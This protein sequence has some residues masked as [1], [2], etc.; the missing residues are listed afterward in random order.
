[1]AQL[2][3]TNRGAMGEPN[4]SP[5]TSPALEWITTKG[6]I[7]EREIRLFFSLYHIDT[8][9]SYLFLETGNGFPYSPIGSSSHQRNRS[10]R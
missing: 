4:F 1:M 8:I 6:G 2:K 9:R 7:G 5:I 10:D 3:G